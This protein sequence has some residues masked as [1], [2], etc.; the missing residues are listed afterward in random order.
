MVAIDVSRLIRLWMPAFA[1]V[2]EFF[3]PMQLFRLFS[4]AAL[5]TLSAGGSTPPR[6]VSAPAGRE[7]RPN[8]IL[9]TLDTTRADRMGF[10]GSQR[11]L[12]PN[13]DGLARQS[14][15]FTR[16]YAQ[17]PLTTPSHAALLT[18]TYP[19]YNHVQDLG[20][21]LNPKLPYLPDLFHQH[22]Y[23]TAAF[24]GSIVLDPDNGGAP[25][26]D[27]GFDFYDARFHNSK[28]GEDRYQSLERRAEDVANHAMGWLSHHQHAPFF[29]WL[30]F[31]DAHE[32]YDPPEPFLSKYPTEPY[33]G[34]IAYTDSVVGSILDV[35]R[36][37]GLYQNTVIAVA[38]DH[39]EAFGEHGEKYHGVFLYDET[40]HVPLLLKLPSEKYAGMRVE[41]RVAL[42]DIA[43]SLLQAA[44]MPVPAV[45]QGQSLLPLTDTPNRGAST[46]NNPTE[47]AIYSET[48]YAHRAFGWSELRSWRVQKYLYVQAPKKELYDQSIDPEAVKNLAP[49]ARAVAETLDGQLS[50]FVGKTTIAAGAHVELEPAQVENLRALG[51]M[52]SSDGN[53]NHSEGG[54]IDPK[55]QIDFANRIHDFLTD[56]EADRFEKAATGLRDLSEKYPAEAPVADLEFG[57]ALV[58]RERYEEALPI[59]RAAVEKM[60]D[61]SMAHYELGLALF[62]LEQ[63]E[64]ALPEVQAA[65]KGK[66]TSSQLHFDLATIDLHLKHVPDAMKEYE[67]TLELDPNHFQANLTYGRLLL[68]EGHPEEALPKLSRAAEVNPESEEAHGFLATADQRLGRQQDAE[69]ERAKASQLKVQ[70]HE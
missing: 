5:L 50:V 4:L 28:P 34:E 30:H 63:W 15:V 22:G 56:I 7:K 64:A 40:I 27:R 68:L 57:R 1:Y 70:P 61:S 69:R 21:P 66:P 52:S 39:G 26:F 65:V 20:E 37:H 44:K 16:A 42:T 6:T 2:L 14:V 35:L 48:E 24:V 36:R 62:K 51:Y 47:R 12:T 11:G 19:Q 13:L 23:Q 33:D 46:K 54:Q 59:L 29:I 58:Y 18:G 45:M 8:V 9:I 10:L 43:P 3:I 41:E 25:G 32:P 49:K 31:Y 55:D 60:P 53:L 67:R 38:A 17:V